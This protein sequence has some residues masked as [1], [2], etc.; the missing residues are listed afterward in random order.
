MVGGLILKECLQSNEVTEIVN[1]V[2]RP[3]KSI[4]NSKLKNVVIEDFQ[5][6]D[7]KN[8][9]F[10]NISSAYFCIGVY[11]GQVKNDLFKTITVDYAVNFAKLLGRNSP[12]AKL[13]LLS[14]AGADRTE[15]SLH[16]R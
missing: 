1:L 6:Y 3:I 11:T 8:E 16:I 4:K 13:C 10:E 15:K 14:G 12:K 2:R 7:Q 5:T 9:L